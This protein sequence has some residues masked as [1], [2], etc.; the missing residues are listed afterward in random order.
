MSAAASRALRAALH[1]PVVLPV[2]ALLL[3]GLLF[4]SGV[5]KAGQQVTGIAVGLAIGAVLVL[6]PYKQL[7][8]KAY[9]FYVANIV[10]LVLVL[11]VAD[12]VKGSQR[13]IKVPVFGNMQPSEFMKL[14]LVLTLSRFIRFK[15]SYK[16]FKGLGAPFLL[17]VVPMAL[18]LRQ[19]DLGTALLCVPILFTM[20][21]VAG[22]RAR[23]L[24]V[25]TVLGL[26]SLAPVYTLLGDYQKARIDGFI[27]HLVSGDA[28]AQERKHHRQAKGYQLY[29]SQIALGS[30][31]LAGVGIGEG[32]AHA[33]A[34]VPENHTDFIFS[35]VGNEAGFLGTALVLALFGALL[36]AI[37]AVA[38]RHREPAGRLLCAGVFALFA[39]QAI[40]NVA[41]TVG[42]LPITGLT[43]PFLS[44]GRSSVVTSLAAI[45]LVCNVAA[46][47]SYEFGPDDFS[48]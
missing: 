8:A 41:M 24:L 47:P 38:W 27:G 36:L 31:G 44:Y 13:W 22:A 15:S 43:L 18:V 46:R 33:A 21:F 30:G 5:D 6:V 1:L 28:P 23:H 2:A 40:V 25:I 39:A 32:N 17:T 48:S 42:L 3:L 16:T 10:L 12:E 14:T 19:P 37:L 9:L 7:V 26:A 35:V 11:F 4:L 20:L 34:W 45:A 29:Q